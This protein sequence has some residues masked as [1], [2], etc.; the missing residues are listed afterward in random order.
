MQ[1]LIQILHLFKSFGR[2]KLFSDVSLSINEG[3]IFALIGENGSGKTT[4]LKLL[5]GAI[6]PD[7]GQL[8]KKDHLKIGFLEQE[9]TDYSNFTVKQYIENGPLLELERQMIS[10]LNDPSQL[11]KWAKLHERFIQL[12]GYERIPLEKVLSGL[13]LESSL[14]ELP[15]AILSS[16]QRIRV[17]LAKAFIQNPDVLLLDEPTNHLDQEMVD[18]LIETLP[19]RKGASVIVSHD[20]KFLNKTCNKLIEIKDGKLFCYGGNYDFYLQEQKRLLENQIKAYEEQKEEREILKQKIK[21]LSFSKKTPTPP[22]CGD[23]MGYNY[24]GQRHQ[25]SQKHIIDGLKSNLNEIEAN[26]IPHPNPKTIKGLYFEKAPLSSHVAIELENVTKSFG[27]KVLFSNFSKVLCKGDRI[28]LMG[29]NGSGKTTLLRCIAKLL[30]VDEGLIR[31]APGAKIA[32]LDQEVELL[33]LE[34]TP[35]EY[36]ENLF[37]LKEEEIR[38]ELQKAALGGEELINRSFSHLSV[39]QRKRLMLLSLILQKPNVLLFD[40]PTNHLDLLTVEAL[41]RALLDFEGAILA[42]SHDVT[43]I[44]KIATEKWIL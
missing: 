13:K 31:Y 22:K 20:R 9:I 14:L 42:V 26:P 23:K 18:W 25:K 12:G 36:F 41:E 11:D 19:L 30:L 33:P 37:H 38:R 4:L 34:K 32:Y 43:F 29:P 2:L 10:C 8:C 6:L 24:R 16:G 44:E 15:M 27:K 17:A 3:E 7:S 39:G 40:E 28:L 1:N 35:H 5:T 21:A